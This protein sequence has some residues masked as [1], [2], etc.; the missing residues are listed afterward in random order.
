MICHEGLGR[1]GDELD[2]RGDLKFMATAGEKIFK[3]EWTYVSRCP[4]WKRFPLLECTS[5]LWAS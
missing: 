3:A 2:P 1:Y 4:Y 5:Y